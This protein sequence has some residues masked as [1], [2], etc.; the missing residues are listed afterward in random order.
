MPRQASLWGQ[1]VRRQP[2][3]KKVR[4]DGYVLDSKAEARRYGELRL[5]EAAG[6][7]KELEVHPTYDLVVNGY[8]I[9]KY[10][11]DFRY[12][13]DGQV[14]VEDVKGGAKSDPNLRAVRLKIKLVRAL[15]GVDVELVHR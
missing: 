8:R 14:I 12:R 7:I 4:V 11:V 15:Y 3:A 10:T 5:Q 6:Q 1:K 2:Q 9:G 13:R